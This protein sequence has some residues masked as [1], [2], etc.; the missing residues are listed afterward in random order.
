MAVALS[1]AVGA[2]IGGYLG[3]GAAQRVS[4]QRVRQAIVAIGLT[5]SAWLAFAYLRAR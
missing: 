2:T 1:M 4:Q 5:S 3:S